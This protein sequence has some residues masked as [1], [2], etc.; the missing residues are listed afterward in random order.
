MQEINVTH[1]G[2]IRFWG[3]WFGRPYDNIHRVTYAVYNEDSDTLVLT[4][5]EYEEC[6]ACSPTGITS[7][8]DTFFIADAKSV[9][10]SWYY[11]GREP[12]KENMY[13]IQ[14]TKENE[15]TVICQR[16]SYYRVQSTKHINPKGFY[17]MEIC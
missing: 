8:E 4:F 12:V 1:C 17:A 10:W 16:Q 14:Y 5:E 9:S 3:D 15:N 13:R 6:V 11:Y 7:T 2:A